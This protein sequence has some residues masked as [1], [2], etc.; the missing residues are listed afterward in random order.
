[1]Y[2][3]ILIK[4]NIER[5]VLPLTFGLFIGFICFIFS[6]IQNIENY[7]INPFIMISIIVGYYIYKMQ[8]EYQLSYNKLVNI[9]QRRMN[10]IR[11]KLSKIKKKIVKQYVKKLMLTKKFNQILFSFLLVPDYYLKLN[12]RK[13]LLMQ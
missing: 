4:Y 12:T 3:D 9:L 6:N 13:E 2:Q 7:I 10:I 5:Y 1:M 8:E 11:Q